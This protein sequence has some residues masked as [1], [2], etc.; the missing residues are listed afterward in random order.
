MFH[1]DREV[2]IELKLGAFKVEYKNQKELSLRRLAGHEQEADEQ[3]SIGI[4]LCTGK[5]Q[6]QIEL[7]ELGRRA[8][9]TAEYLTVLPFWEALEAKLHQLIEVARS[10]LR[11]DRD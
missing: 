8:I 1:I 3:P 2:A 9:H 6:E 4:I 7:L 10:R 11:D 5:K